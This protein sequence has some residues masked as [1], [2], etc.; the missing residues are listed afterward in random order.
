VVRL[1]TGLKNYFSEPGFSAGGGFLISKTCIHI[2]ALPH[3]AKKENLMSAHVD[4][5]ASSFGRP[6]AS[7]AI[8]FG[9]LVAG[10][11]DCLAASIS[12]LIRG[13]TPV[14]VWQYVASGLLGPD[15][16]NHGYATVALGLAIHFLIAFGAATVYYFASRK[17]SALVRHPLV[18]GPLYG[19][20]VFF[21]MSRVVSPLSAVRRSP[22]SFSQMMIGIGIHILFVGLPIALV[23]HR[24][25]KTN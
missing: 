10:V 15:S 2:S 19:V 3:S 14:R 16:Y 24:S 1:Q 17:I 4:N 7:Y 9:G 18:C 6:R 11:L 25:A 5:D 20:A 12:A 22:F 21:F 13:S 8:G 23:A